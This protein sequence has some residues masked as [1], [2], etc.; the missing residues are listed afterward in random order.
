MFHLSRCNPQKCTAFV[1]RSHRAADKEWFGRNGPLHPSA[2]QA[3]LRRKE[4]YDSFEQRRGNENY[5][6]INA[7]SPNSEDGPVE[8]EVEDEIEKQTNRELEEEDP[9]KRSNAFPAKQDGSI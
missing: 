4:S 8:D 6:I 9:P 3:L 7:G 2:V 5:I 1:D